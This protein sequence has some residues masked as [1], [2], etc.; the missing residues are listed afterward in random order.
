MSR[1]IYLSITPGPQYDC[2]N[3]ICTKGTEIGWLAD[4]IR[5]RYPDEKLFFVMHMPDDE[6]VFFRIILNSA[7]GDTKGAAEWLSEKI[8]VR[9]W[10]R[11]PDNDYKFSLVID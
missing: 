10:S 6:S 5:E 2:L 11:T 1:R 3:I 7:D 8:I 9:G 4:V